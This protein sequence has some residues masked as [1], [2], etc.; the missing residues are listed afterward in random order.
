LHQKRQ[1]IATEGLDI[2]CTAIP[3]LRNGFVPFCIPGDY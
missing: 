3:P 1:K 2:D